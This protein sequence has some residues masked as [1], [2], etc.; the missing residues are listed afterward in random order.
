MQTDAAAV[1]KSEWFATTHWTTVITAGSHKPL[2][3]SAALES[4]CQRYWRPIYTFIRSRG[5]TPDN[6]QDLTQEF[7]ARFLDGQLLRSADS[8]KG[9]FRTLLLTAVTRFLVNEWERSQTQKRGGGVSHISIDEMLAEERNVSEPTDRA[10]PEVLFEKR[11]AETLL[12]TVLLRLK[13]EFQLNGQ[14]ERFD[15]LKPFLAWD[16]HAR[17]VAEISARLGLSEAA[18]HSAVHRL[19]HRYGELLRDEIAQ[20]IADPA[21]IDEELRYLVRVLSA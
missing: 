5:H 3:A 21:E 9:K 18:V 10:T 4:L 14:S 17:P 6:A 20:T 19:R 12:E 8:A 13:R 16:K 11:W 1:K 2:E 7:F 15:F